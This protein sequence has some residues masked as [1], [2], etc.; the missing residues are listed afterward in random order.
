M[1]VSGRVREVGHL[2]RRFAGSWSRRPPRAADLVW[3]EAH[4]LSAEMAMWNRFGPSD[5]RHTVAVARR[6][7]ALRPAATRPEIAGA[8]LHDIG[9]LSSGLGTI[10]R[11]VATVVGPRTTRFRTYHAHETLGADALA[12]IGS[13]PVT[14]SMVRGDGDPVLVAA[15]HAADDI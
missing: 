15:L 9:K 12:H 1:S 8:L 3:V 2:A 13:D 10:G 5:Q 7:V 6:F 4:L 14:V 11:V